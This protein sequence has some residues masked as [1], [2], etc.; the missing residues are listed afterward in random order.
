MSGERVLRSKLFSPS[1]QPT[2]QESSF[3]SNDGTTDYQWFSE[4]GSYQRQQ[5]DN[6]EVAS[7]RSRLS[8]IDGQLAQYEALSRTLDVNLAEIDIDNFRSEDLHSALVSTE[9]LVESDGELTT[10]FNEPVDRLVDSYNRVP[11]SQDDASSM[12]DLSLYKSGPLF[13]PYRDAFPQ[14]RQEVASLEGRE[15][16]GDAE[17]E[18]VLTLACRD[19]KTN[20]KIAFEGMM[21]SVGSDGDYNQASSETSGESSDSAQW[22]EGS[23]LGH[24][25][26]RNCRF[27]TWPHQRSPVR[28][29]KSPVPSRRVPKLNI[30]HIDTEDT[31]NGN[32]IQETKSL[33]NL[34]KQCL[35]KNS[36]TKHR[37]PERE[38]KRDSLSLLQIYMK[39]KGYGDIQNCNNSKEDSQM[40]DSL[41]TGEVCCDGG[42][43][44]IADYPSSADEKAYDSSVEEKPSYKERTDEVTENSEFSSS[45]VIDAKAFNKSSPKKLTAS[46][47]ISNNNSSIDRVIAKIQP[48][49]TTLPSTDEEPSFSF[50]KI[51]TRDSG[52]QTLGKLTKD[53]ATSITL[54]TKVDKSVNTEEKKRPIVM[55]FPNY[56]LPDLDFL[57]EKQKDKVVLSPLPYKAPK[58]TS[59]IS[60]QKVKRHCKGRPSS[61]NDLDQAKEKK[62]FKHIKDW[63]S[64]KVLLPKEMQEILAG[65]PEQEEDESEAQIKPRPRS[66]DTAALAK[67]SPR[68]LR[69]NS[70]GFSSASTRT[71]S[72]QPSSG[73]RGSST[74]CSN[75]SGGS[76]P[77]L[78]S[79][80]GS[81]PLSP[82][83]DQSQPPPLPERTASLQCH[84]Y[85]V[86][87]PRPP[88]PRGILRKVKSESHSR[89]SKQKNR[90]SLPIL[91]D[92]E[93]DL[94]KYLSE[95]NTHLKSELNRL[96]KTL[97]S[98]GLTVT[99]D[100]DSKEIRDRVSKMLVIK[101][102]AD[103]I[104]TA[105]LD[106]K[107][108]LVK[109]LVELSPPHNTPLK[110]TPTSSAP[111]TPPEDEY[112]EE[113]HKLQKAVSFAEQLNKLGNQPVEQRKNYQRKTPKLRSSLPN[114]PFGSLM[115]PYEDQD[116]RFIECEL[117]PVHM[118]KKKGLISQVISSIDKVIRELSLYEDPSTLYTSQNFAIDDVTLKNVN[119]IV[120]GLLSPSLYQVMS[121]GLQD[122]VKT[123][124][125]E[126][127]NS[128]WR[129]VEAASRKG[130][131]APWFNEL[132]LWLSSEES[133]PEGPLRFHA[134]VVG[135]L[136]MGGLAWWLENLT[137]RESVLHRHYKS[138]AFLYACS[139]AT[140]DLME[141]LLASL[142]QLSGIRLNLNVS[143]NA[144]DRKK[145]T[146]ST[147]STS[148]RSST[149]LKVTPPASPRRT[150]RQR[151]QTLMTPK[152]V[153]KQLRTPAAKPVQKNP[154]KVAEQKE[155][156]SFGTLKK[157][158]QQ[159]C[160]EKPNIKRA[161]KSEGDK[162]STDHSASPV[163][164]RIPRPAAS[165]I[166]KLQPRCRFSGSSPVLGPPI[167]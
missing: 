13:S 145:I 130:P 109:K 161:A 54:L 38:F 61:C 42:E 149:S 107:K 166:P 128:V 19:S 14:F 143:I 115:S 86:P 167:L 58:S 103:T 100:A 62:S 33:P 82:G 24:S 73:Y 105:L 131:S 71:T 60:K 126:V 4:S 91:Q 88:P 114:Q 15:D 46:S 6:P 32:D 25:P 152:P 48:F 164:S 101:S 80:H 121:D 96:E 116:D 40:E 90:L 87:P 49:G 56:T 124:F 118:M 157:Q 51:T 99:K 67:D 69:M 83:F 129:V 3:T 59:S 125:G 94:I 29:K 95:T 7:S 142:S 150:E 55:V 97:N 45:L 162:N 137:A 20:Y 68:F 81:Y 28:Q 93:E 65:I 119:K 23:S 64:L 136:K 27:G 84:E 123:L 72:T 151:P 120:I 35:M 66:C 30:D 36:I 135:L 153:S 9:L 141:E 12:T 11:S 111:E 112:G 133:L 140:H 22:S 102:H 21:G 57:S 37:S 122:T 106:Q 10:A 41:L 163:K 146:Q 78:P 31:A 117:S 74:Y 165:G 44:F 18:L 39:Q 1:S 79:P 159:L 63:D 85:E 26:I 104:A 89:R 108:K 144:E 52:A 113:F 154:S 110:A 138:T 156:K 43:C 148:S 160:D 70:S 158:W 92:D 139:S 16:Q 147:A 132:V 155:H 134:F 77:L 75:P 76:S 5:Q 34:Y 50:P 127:P 8:V 2:A 17:E 53:M 47:L 98:F